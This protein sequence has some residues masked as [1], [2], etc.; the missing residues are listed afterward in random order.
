MQRKQQEKFFEGYTKAQSGIALTEISHPDSVTSKVFGP[1]G[2][3]QGAQFYTA[4][5]AVSTWQSTQLTDMDTLKRMNPQEL[6]AHVASSSGK[7]MTGDPFADQQ[8]QKGLLEASA[9]L[10]NTIAK[11]R[12]GW[13][14][15]EAVDAQHTAVMSGGATLQTIAASQARLE[16]GGTDDGVAASQAM[17]SFSGMLGQPHGMD[18][19]NYHKFLVGTARDLMQ[20][21][22]GY[23]IEVMRRSPAYSRLNPDEVDK[24]DEQYLK[25]GNRANG[26][27][28]STP[29]FVERLIRHDM[30]VHGGDAVEGSFTSPLE[31]AADLAAINGDI[32][33]STGFNVDV[34]D[35]KDERSAGM[36]VT[37]MAIAAWNKKRDRAWEQANR[38]EERAYKRNEADR[39]EHA[40]A[41]VAVTAW[42]A[43]NP[44]Q[45]VMAG[46]NKDLIEAQAN[47]DWV[48]GN[49]TN[50]VR[51]FQ[52][53]YVSDAVKNAARAGVEASAG[54]Q[55]SKD[56]E[57]VY[58]QW[59]GLYAAK[60][61]AALAYYGSYH[62]V[63][64]KYDSLVRQHTDPIVAFSKT[65]GD[66]AQYGTADVSP[67]RRKEVVSS[68]S[69]VLS[70]QRGYFFDV[71]GVANLGTLGESIVK[72]VALSHVATAGNNSGQTTET[73]MK[74]AVGAAKA[75]GEYERYGQFA[76]TNKAGTAPLGQM[77]GLQDRDAAAVFTKVYNEHL[78]QLGIA[79]NTDPQTLLRYDNNGHPAM[80]AVVEGRRG[81]E[82]MAITYE[83][84]ATAAHDYV[85][86]RTGRPSDRADP[87]TAKYLR[88]HPLDRAVYNL[89]ND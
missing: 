32:K 44:V 83:Q 86:K 23:A 28:A 25:F 77:L 22:N 15:Q 29:A 59:H 64:Q 79:A 1:S 89:L 7:A 84:L 57:R 42:T 30:R 87:K 12:Y 71:G 3:A 51:T 69:A 35:A 41:L 80:V 62:A 85:S 88:S 53:G 47:N 9:P 2:F 75:S 74:E 31:A 14:Q 61:A 19:T 10:L 17:A 5:A 27:A 26:L 82:R 55:Y 46:V 81:I 50:I 38:D 39:E 8:I 56:F 34:F 49:L 68:M 52:G 65:F 48:G 21:G 4:Q 24:L 43:G 66:A 20:S 45:A 13:Q 6:A 54:E 60:P 36:T 18:D 72:R 16:S 67:E 33:R 78:A 37:D 63:M 70:S 40:K 58:Q 76:W 11:E 73:L